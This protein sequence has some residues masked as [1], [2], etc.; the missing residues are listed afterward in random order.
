MQHKVR[1]KRNA[2]QKAK[3]EKVCRKIKPPNTRRSTRKAKVDE[4]SKTKLTRMRRVEKAVASSRPLS[5]EKPLEEN[6]HTTDLPKQINFGWKV[7]K[8]LI[9]VQ[10]KMQNLVQTWPAT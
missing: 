7:D 5:F 3:S 8:R 2:K 10:P 6:R 9:V 4:G 1:A